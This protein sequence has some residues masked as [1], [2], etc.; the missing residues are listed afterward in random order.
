MAGT[1]TN[2]TKHCIFSFVQKYKKLEYTFP[3]LKT[4][5]GKEKEVLLKGL[6]E[7]AEKQ[8]LG[9]Q[10]CGDGNDYGRYGI[11]QSGCITAQLMEQAIGKQ[12]KTLKPKPN[13]EGCGC[14][15]STDIG[16]YDT[17]PN[18]CRHCYTNKNQAVAIENYRRHD[19]SSPLLID[20]V[21]PSDII[22]E[23]KQVSFLV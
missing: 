6:S 23:S 14:I 17:C 1:L 12:L 5:T 22:S 21:L 15:H 9:L 16:L 20:N 2:Y 8:R 13:R 19:P 18:G 3:E 4:V 11:Q 10:T 7:I